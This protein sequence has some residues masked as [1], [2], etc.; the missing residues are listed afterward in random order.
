MV[1]APPMESAT[2]PSSP[3]ETSLATSMADVDIGEKSEKKFSEATVAE[4]NRHLMEMYALKVKPD[5]FVPP[6]PLRGVDVTA[7]SRVETCFARA[8]RL[9]GVEVPGIATSVDQLRGDDVTKLSESLDFK[10]VVTCFGADDP[11]NH[12]DLVPSGTSNALVSVKPIDVIAQRHYVFACTTMQQFFN[13]G[14][15]WY[16]TKFYASPNN[17]ADDVTENV[18]GND[19]DGEFGGGLTAEQQRLVDEQHRLDERARQLADERRQVAIDERRKTEDQRREVQ[20]RRNKVPDVGRSSRESQFRPPPPES[21]VGDD[22]TGGGSNVSGGVVRSRRRNISARITAVG[23]PV[24]KNYR[25]TGA[26]MFNNFDE[27]FQDKVSRPFAQEIIEATFEA[28]GVPLD[29]PDAVKFAEDLLWSFIVAVTASNKADYNRTYDIPVRAIKRGG[30]TLNSVD[31][32]FAVFS[33]LLEFQFGV[34]RRQFARGVSDDLKDFLRREEN[35]ALLPTLAT[36]V[37]C[38]PLLAYLA[39]DGSTHCTGLT[40]REVTFTRTLESRNLFERDDV[41]AQ[42]SSDRLMQGVSGG[43]RSVSVR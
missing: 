31:A 33:K 28:W 27:L 5:L 7:T 41:L 37:G 20:E 6:P 39:F 8:C 40:T 2:S 26:V 30:E 35:Q 24:A 34:T 42:G 21:I 23:V 38:E 43:V 16:H 11:R 15:R 4:M 9:A 17:D 18:P 29:Q 32:D 3:L 25:T 22:V 14:N 10:V 19:D 36:R 1:T 12:I 13:K